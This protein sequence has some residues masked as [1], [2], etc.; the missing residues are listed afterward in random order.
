[1]SSPTSS[2]RTGGTSCPR[3]PGTCTSLAPT[4]RTWATTRA[5]PPAT[6]T[7]PPRASSASLL[8]ST[9]WLEVRRA[10]GPGQSGLGAGG[11]PWLPEPKR[12][13]PCVHR[14][15]PLRAHHQGS[16]PPRDLR[17]AR[18]AGHPGVLRLWEVG[19]G[20]SVPGQG[21]GQL[22]APHQGSGGS[23]RC[24]AL[25]LLVAERCWLQLCGPG[26]GPTS[27]RVP[28]WAAPRGG[29][30]RLLTPSLPL[31]GRERP[32][33]A[34]PLLH[35]VML[36]A[37][38]PGLLGA[39]SGQHRWRMAWGR[40]RAGQVHCAC[41]WVW[42]RRRQRQASRSQVLCGCLQL[43]VPSESLRGRS[44][45]QVLSDAGP[46]F[47]QASSTFPSPCSPKTQRGP[48]KALQSADAWEKARRA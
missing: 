37:L 14:H 32:E 47:P 28:P 6:W 44:S 15:P 17:A 31:A 26:L 33:P 38:G 35:M 18:P 45:Q 43:P 20:Q 30:G 2:P 22:G 40:E 5:W 8:S 24:W 48:V 27:E 42:I 16:F 41:F 39:L 21:E 7:S 1:M 11:R 12:P 13:N 3:P 34:P 23:R 9:W 4:P 29:A 46:L 19:V 36:P 10:W 25:N